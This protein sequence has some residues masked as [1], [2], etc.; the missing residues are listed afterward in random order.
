MGN[1][2]YSVIISNFGNRSDRFLS[3]Y[4]EDRTLEQLFDRPRSA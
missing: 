1:D 3:G 4:G 2:K